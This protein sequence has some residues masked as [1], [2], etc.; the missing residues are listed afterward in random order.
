MNIFMRSFSAFGPLELSYER[1]R[2]CPDSASVASTLEWS[3]NVKGLHLLR[4]HAPMAEQSD[5]LLQNTRSVDASGWSI[6]LQSL[7][8]AKVNLPVMEELRVLAPLHLA[9]LRQIY[10]P[11]LMS[12]CLAGVSDGHM[13]DPTQGLPA[14]VV[15]AATDAL[16]A[17][18]N[19]KLITLEY[20]GDIN[21]CKEVTVTLVPFYTHLKNHNIKLKLK[22][23]IHEVEESDWYEEG[24]CSLGE[25]CRLYKPLKTCIT[26][27]R[28][29]LVSYEFKMMDRARAVHLPNL[30]Y[31][32]LQLG[33]DD[34][35]AET[36]RWCMEIIRFPRLQQITF[37][38]Y[39]NSQFYLFRVIAAYLPSLP[40]TCRCLAVYEGMDRE[41]STVTRMTDSLDFQYFARNCERVGVDYQTQDVHK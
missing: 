24:A 11:K 3:S 27:L 23:D 13:A 21:F 10:A 12:L 26:V 15:E 8:S 2:V 29:D 25:L 1:I 4:C 18:K 33:D 41:A 17:C 7:T 20:R 35:G 40:A 37:H 28:L 34:T 39:Y 31:L 30:E 5:C 36:L 6:S 16:K 22:L 9:F 14:H 32:H 19:I 38:V